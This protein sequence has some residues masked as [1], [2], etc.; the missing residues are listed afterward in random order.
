MTKHSADDGFTIL[1]I[2]VAFSVLSICVVAYYESA[3]A[4]YAALGRVRAQ[5]IAIIVGL[6]RLAEAASTTSPVPKGN[7]DRF[8]K[9]EVRATALRK[10]NTASR[11]NLLEYNAVD[12]SGRP[13]VTIKTVHVAPAETR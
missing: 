1:E 2:L 5:E 6:S 4:S 13:V 3:A 11:L 7:F 8:V 12:W 10:A 9:W